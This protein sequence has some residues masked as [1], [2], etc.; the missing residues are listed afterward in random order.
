[1][2]QLGIATLVRAAFALVLEV[3]V[4]ANGEQLHIKL[5]LVTITQPKLRKKLALEAVKEPLLETTAFRG[6][7][8][9]SKYKR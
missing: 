4:V 9:V 2:E 8:L 3:Q 5:L 1:M 7:W 6:E